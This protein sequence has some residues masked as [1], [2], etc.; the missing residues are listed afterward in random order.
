MKAT[1]WID[2]IKVT[3]NIQSDY[4]IAKEL[5]LSRN[6]ISTYRGG[7]SNTM[8]EN[9]SLK[10]ASMLGID[11]AIVLLDQAKERTTNSCVKEAW[12]RLGM[13]IDFKSDALVF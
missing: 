3:K 10:V 11:P 2:R 6:T 4:Q 8:D 1:E 9:T 7:R 13:R 5:G 12:N